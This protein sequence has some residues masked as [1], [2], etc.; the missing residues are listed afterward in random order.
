[1]S[2]LPPCKWRISFQDTLA[3][4]LAFGS[5]R[6]REICE[7]QESALL[8]LGETVAEALRTRVADLRAANSMSDLIAGSPRRVTRS[9]KEHFILDLC[10]GQVLVFRSNHLRDQKTVVIDWNKVTRV[11]ILQIEADAHD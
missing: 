2:T 1:L 10:D 6:L 7:K 5:R 11:Q 8:E 3:Q 4:D 9:H